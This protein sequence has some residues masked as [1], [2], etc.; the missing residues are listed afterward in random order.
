MNQGYVAGTG[1]DVARLPTAAPPISAAGAGYDRAPVTE[2]IGGHSM[3]V[4]PSEEGYYA[5]DPMYYQQERP[6]SA[7]SDPALRSP[8]ASSVHY[9]GPYDNSSAHGYTPV[10]GR[11][12]SNVQGDFVAN[13]P[14]QEAYPKAADYESVNSLPGAQPADPFSWMSSNETH[15]PDDDL[16]DPA[17]PLRGGVRS[18]ARGFFNIG[19]M[20]IVVLAL[21]MLFVG[22]PVLHHYTDGAEEESQQKQLQ[23]GRNA[24]PPY[25]PEEQRSESRLY[26]PA[27]GKTKNNLI[28]PDTPPEAHTIPSTYALNKNKTFQL[29]FS[30][31]FNV[32]GR[33]FYPGDD[34]YWEA[35]D[36]HY[37]GTNNYE[38]YDPEAITTRNGKLEIKLDQHQEHNKNFRG[39]MLQS[40]NKFCYRGGLLIA[41]IQLPGSPT[42]GQLWPA[43]W[44]M[45]NLGRAGYGASLDGTWPYSYDKCDVGTVIN[46][47][48]FDDDE[49]PWPKNNTKAGDVGFNT[50]H[51]TRSISFLSGQKLSACTCPGDDHPGPRNDVGRSAPEIDVFEAQVQDTTMKMSQSFQMAPYNYLYDIIAPLPNASDLLH[52]QPTE[53]INQTRAFSSYHDSWELNIYTGEA[54]QQSL[55]GV[56]NGSQ[57]AA[58]TV[59][60]RYPEEDQF[61][62]YS[63]EY[64]PGEDGY[65]SWTS[66]GNKTWEIH[67]GA[68]DPDPRTEIGHRTFPKEP[69]Y[70]ILNLGISKNFVTDFDWEELKKIWE[71]YGSM[72]MLVDWVRVY[73]D[74]KQIDVGCDPEDMPTKDY[75]E[76]HADAYHN[77]NLTIWGEGE[78]GYKADWPRNRLFGDGKACEHPPIKQPGNNLKPD[79]PYVKS[80][81]DK[82][83]DFVAQQHKDQLEIQELGFVAGKYNRTGINGPYTF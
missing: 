66:A 6:E 79:K 26:G 52:P 58:Q 47:T 17:K 4:S 42:L 49:R 35:V 48:L 19:T 80:R 7:L 21:L 39:G 82:N 40:W 1:E 9:G 61:A 50:Q 33:S 34:P 51:H 31:E 74:P 55:S 72:K 78:G 76:R 56:S 14:P 67:H 63:L 25:M 43:F 44:I 16:H 27:D 11:V 8:M 37:W 28:D 81:I 18:P 45:G 65:V 59:A 2:A 3:L 73:Q 69:M 13:M 64:K 29:V 41:S 75:I 32:D 77:A 30:D 57:T 36:L 70:I 10:I 23:E 12:P 15:E 22:Y 53:R 38:W 71:E 24:K 46:Q 62:T 5:N 54:T 68:L 60:H 20:L 83:K